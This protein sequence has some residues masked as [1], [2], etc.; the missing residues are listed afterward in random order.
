MVTQEFFNIFLKYF[1]KFKDINRAKRMAAAD[2]KTSRVP[3]NSELYKLLSVKLGETFIRKPSRTLS[4]VA[5]V[6]VMVRPQ[7]SC[8][9]KCS[10]C[11]VSTIAPRSYTG[12]EPTS[13]RAR[14]VDYDPY[15]Q[16]KARLYHYQIQNH[17]AQKLDVIIMGGTFLEMDK[18]YKYYFVKAIY[19]AVNDVHSK[20]LEHAKQINE[21]AER[22]VVGLTIETRP[23]V[24]NIDELLYYGATK[25]EL[26]VQSLYND[27]LELVERGH[28]VDTVIEATYRLKNAGYKILYHMML[29]LP[30]SNPEK[31][32]EMFKMLFNDKRFRPDMLKIYPT[33]V[34]KGSKL[35][36]D[37]LEGNYIPYDDDT[38]AYV[39]ANAFKYIPKYVRVQRI[40]RDIP[41]HKIEAGVKKANIRELAIQ[42]ANIKGVHIDEIR[43][44]E[45][46]RKGDIAYDPDQSSM[47]ELRYEASNGLEYFISIEPKD[48]SMIYGFLRLRIPDNWSV[49]DI[50]NSAIVRELHVYGRE[51]KIGEVGR[52]QHRGI[53]KMLMRRAEEIAQ[54]HN[55]N[56]SVI[57]AVGVREYYRKLG[58]RLK[59]RYMFKDLR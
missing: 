5:P 33:L 55:L 21:T 13:L 2:L 24:Y 34:V 46:G 17:H 48:R 10:Y 27:V 53:G 15:R 29:G 11:P 23:D 58:Y 16:V 51:T 3:K 1:E 31:D 43:T 50:K 9:W 39:I 36:N 57:S 25:I 14:A 49:E 28:D 22:R 32:I 38:A 56:I 26:G 8:R 12:H 59:G 30:G 18:D 19:D 42:L 54:D 35:Y 47:F 52:I 4:G 7:G 41:S 20:D 44:N 37:Y 40:N 45:A 6:A